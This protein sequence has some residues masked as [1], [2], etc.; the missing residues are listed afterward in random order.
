MSFCLF[1][2]LFKALYLDMLQVG[3]ASDGGKETR[4]QWVGNEDRILAT[5]VSKVKD[6]NVPYLQLFLQM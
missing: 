2:D 3:T 1:G 5:G 4:V 6:D